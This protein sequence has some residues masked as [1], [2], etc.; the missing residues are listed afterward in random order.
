MAVFEQSYH[1][2]RI[3]SLVT[4]DKNSLFVY[5]IKRFDER[6][7]KY[8]FIVR[9]SEINWRESMLTESTNIR[10]TEPVRKVRSLPVPEFF[11]IVR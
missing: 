1:G 6:L 5:S 3:K 4:H 2:K 8:L 11:N 9:K 7:V 10:Q